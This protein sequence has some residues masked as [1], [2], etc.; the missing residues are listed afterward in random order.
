MKF[1]SRDL[2]LCSPLIKGGN[3]RLHHLFP[4]SGNRQ[5][6]KG[7]IE[8]FSPYR[9]VPSAGTKEQNGGFLVG[10]LDTSRNPQ[11]APLDI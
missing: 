1:F 5:E 2:F 7:T 8:P 6:T 4:V 3:K 9:T 10:N 11:D